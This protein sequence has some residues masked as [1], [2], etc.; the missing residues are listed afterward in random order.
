[1]ADERELPDISSPVLYTKIVHKP[2]NFSIE[3][4]SERWQPK[5]PV[6]QQSM[7]IWQRSTPRNFVASA[8]IAA[9]VTPFSAFLLLGQL[10]R[11][12][13]TKRVGLGRHLRDLSVYQTGSLYL[14]LVV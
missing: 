7:I 10:L 1:M 5:L 11:L 12:L 6:S 14:L 3:R 4:G 9:G 13:S 8:C 2:Y